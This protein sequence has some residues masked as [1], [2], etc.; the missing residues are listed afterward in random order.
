MGNKRELTNA[1]LD[2]VSGGTDSGTID[3][4]SIRELI[5]FKHYHAQC[6]QTFAT[7][8]KPQ[9]CPVCGRPDA[10]DGPINEL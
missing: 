9:Y 2:Q 5:I 1:E 6:M 7:P 10:P 4:A 3:D 8:S